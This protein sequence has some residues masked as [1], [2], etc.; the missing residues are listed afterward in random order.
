MNVFYSIQI[1][2]KIKL[3]TRIVTGP[4]NFMAR[5]SMM[6]FLSHIPTYTKIGIFL[7]NHSIQN[8]IYRFDVRNA[9]IYVLI[10]LTS[11]NPSPKIEINVFT[12]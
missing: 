5:Y 3:I 1:L 2:I 7:A 6:K 12:Y 9:T 10:V 4:F 11:A 8:L